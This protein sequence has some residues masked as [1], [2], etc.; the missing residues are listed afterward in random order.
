MA[1]RRSRAVALTRNGKTFLPLAHLVLAW[2]GTLDQEA[3]SPVVRV[4]FEPRP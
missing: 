3:G 2:E 1:T 4:W